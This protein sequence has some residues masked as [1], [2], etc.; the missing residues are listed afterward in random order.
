MQEP[1]LRTVCDRV[2]FQESSSDVVR[3]SLDSFLHMVSELDAPK[4]A[5]DWCRLDRCCPS[6]HLPRHPGIKSYTLQISQCRL[7]KVDLMYAW[8]RSICCL[9]RTSAAKGGR[10]LPLLCGGDEAQA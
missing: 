1:V 3:V 2:A 8:A 4:A 10:P 5:G 9:Q 6:C 7:H